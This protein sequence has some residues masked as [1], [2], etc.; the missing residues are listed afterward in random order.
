MKRVILIVLDSLGIGH[1]EDAFKF[2]DVGT[3]TLYHIY[4]NYP[5]MKMDNMI[6]LG[7]LN[8][9]KQDYSKKDENPKGVYARLQEVSNGKDTTIGHWEIAG[10]KIDK[11]FNVFPDGFSKEIIEEFEK[12][13]GSKILCNKP[14]SGTVVIEEYAKEHIKTKKPIV[15]T[16]KDSVFQIAAHEDII[17]VERLYEICQIARDLLV[18]ENAVARVIAR[19]FVGEEGSFKRTANRRDFSLSP[20]GETVLDDI[21]DAG[22]DV[23]AVGKIED[24]FNK[25]GITY[26]VHTES[27]DDGVDKTIEYLKTAKSG[28]IFTNLVDFDALYGH[29]RDVLGYKNAIEEFDRRLPEIYDNMKENDLLILTADHGN[30]PTYKGTDHTRED[31]FMLMYKKSIEPK[32]LG[33]IKGFY[34]IAATVADYLEI[35]YRGHG[36]SYL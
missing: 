19:P 32:N 28:L 26:S 18:G 8:I 10:L 23:Y 7:L 29:R 36:K 4:K 35:K 16:S 21:V 9:D 12:R 3:N 13:I 17:S 14:Y 6:K 34:N 5:Q 22:L 1:A 2:D 27:N 20:F 24:I 30:D 15:Y 11:P 31:V 25:K 33:T